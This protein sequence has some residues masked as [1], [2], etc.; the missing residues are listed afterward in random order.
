MENAAKAVAG[1]V[2]EPIKVTQSFPGKFFGLNVRHEINQRQR[3]LLGLLCLCF[4]YVMN[5]LSAHR[6]E[7]VDK[8]FQREARAFDDLILRLFVF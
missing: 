1:G 7:N 5:F 6:F 8:T 4:A 3:L 2:S